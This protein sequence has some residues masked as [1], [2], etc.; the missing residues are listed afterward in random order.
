MAPFPGLVVAL[1]FATMAGAQVRPIETR[2]YD[3]DSGSL[4]NLHG[5]PQLL[6]SGEV[7]VPKAAWVRLHF[8]DTELPEGSQLR[9]TSLEDNA[10]QF[11]DASSLRDYANGSAV[12]NGDRV[13]VEI[14]AGP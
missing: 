14:L 11:F 3:L 9:L 6:F 2:E 4:D 8:A 7:L 10:S 1:L 5:W 13:R 12:F